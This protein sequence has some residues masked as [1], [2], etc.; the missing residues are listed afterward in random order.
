MDSLKEIT[1]ICEQKRNLYDG[2]VDNYF[3]NYKKEINQVITTLA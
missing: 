2:C 1:S 3:E